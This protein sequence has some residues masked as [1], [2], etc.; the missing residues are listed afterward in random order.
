VKRLDPEKRDIAVA[1]RIKG[2]FLPEIAEQLDISIST[3]HK[4]TRD[5][6]KPH[7]VSGQTF[8]SWYVLSKSYFDGSGTL[9]TCLCMKCNKQKDVY[10]GNLKRQK[11]LSCGCERG[12]KPLGVAPLNVVYQYYK[13]G[14]KR[15]RLD[16][17]LSKEHFEKLIMSECFYCGL[18]LSMESKYKCREPYRYNGVDRID[19]N[20]GYTIEN[21]VSCCKAC[22]VSKSSLSYDRFLKKLAASNGDTKC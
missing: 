4:W 13:Q 7:D 19:S 11:S 5:I 20:I 18:R 1:L 21:S 12:R 16:F 3:V 17:F 2:L 15:R 6:K 14:A 9:Y 22:N 8:G 10:V